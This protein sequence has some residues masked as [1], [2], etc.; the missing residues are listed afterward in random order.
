MRKL[1]FLKGER[2]G[3]SLPFL[4]TREKETPEKRK[5]K[6]RGHLSSFYSVENRRGGSHHGGEP[7]IWEGEKGENLPGRFLLLPKEGGGG[8]G[9]LAGPGKQHEGKRKDRASRPPSEEKRELILKHKSLISSKK[10]GEKSLYYLGE[11]RK[12]SSE[13]KNQHHRK[14]KEHLKGNHSTARGG[15]KSP[16]LLQSPTWR[17]KKRGTLI[18][19]GIHIRGGGKR[20]E[21]FPIKSKP[22]GG[23]FFWREGKGKIRLNLLLWREEI[24]S[25]GV[26]NKKKG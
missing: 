19:W 18:K 5:R 17:R 12:D 8:R 7:R 15:E 11:K 2:R 6:G 4:R 26:T 3:I 10:G 25:T 16:R 13:K 14:N 9:I 22:M 23:I 24:S 21:S 1:L 20:H